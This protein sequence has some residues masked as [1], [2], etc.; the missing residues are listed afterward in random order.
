MAATALALESRGR[1]I[2]QAL[3]RISAAAELAHA[4]G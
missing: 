3:V 2:G 4:A 1:E